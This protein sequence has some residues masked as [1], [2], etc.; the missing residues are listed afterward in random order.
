[1]KICNSNGWSDFVIFSMISCVNFKSNSLRS[2]RTKL[3]M[4]SRRVVNNFTKCCCAFLTRYKVLIALRSSTVSSLLLLF[5]VEAP[6][7]FLILPLRCVTVKNLQTHRQDRDGHENNTDWMRITTKMTLRETSFN[8]QQ[9]WQVL[10][11]AWY[12]ALT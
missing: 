3:L 9:G 6:R 2:I 4:S 11:K 8:N 12:L 10:R 1:M 5:W 7:A